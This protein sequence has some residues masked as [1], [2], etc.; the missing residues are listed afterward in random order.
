MVQEK[1][2]KT[3]NIENDTLEKINFISKNNG[4]SQTEIINNALKLGLMF[5]EQKKQQE[6]TKGYNFIKLAG[7]VSSPEPFNASDEIK[8]FRKGEL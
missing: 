3:F 6:K 5:W 7:I 1:T 4:I 2:K 8:K